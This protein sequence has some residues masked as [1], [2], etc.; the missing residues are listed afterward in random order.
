M[1]VYINQKTQYSVD[2]YNI[3]V[4]SE[5]SWVCFPPCNFKIALKYL[6]TFYFQI[7]FKFGLFFATKIKGLQR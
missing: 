1:T 5:I 7:N 6:D 2:F 4:K 3:M